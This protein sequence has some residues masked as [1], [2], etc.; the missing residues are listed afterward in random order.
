MV[1]R[2]ILELAVFVCGAVVMIYEII[3]SR[4]VSPFIGTSTYVWTS[5]IGVILAALSL[6]YWLGGR[7]ADRRPHVRI[8]AAVVL[9]AAGLIS[10]TVLLKDLVLTFIG[11]LPTGLEIKAVLASAALFAPASIALGFVTPYAVK[12]KTISLDDT[13]KTVGRLYALSTVG[14]IVGT[15][16]AG[17]VLI[18]FVGSTRTLYILAAVL[19][20]TGVSLAPLKLDRTVVAIIVVF[21]TGIVSNEA[22][23]YYLRT[24]RGLLDIDTEYNRVQIFETTDPTTGRPIRA[25]SI[26]P[27]FVQSTIFLDGP[28][29]YARYT[30][31]YHLVRHLRPDFRR[32]LMIGGAGYSF[33]QDH[34][35]VYPNA[36]IDVVEIDPGMTEIA[37]RH[38]RL[39]DDP[40][41]RIIH[42]DGRVF[43]NRAGSGTYDAVFIDAFSSLFSVPYQ[44]T[45]IEAVKHVDRVLDERGVAIVNIGSALSGDASRFLHAEL[46]TYSAVFPHVDIFKV[47]IDR[48]DEHV[49][50]VILV[51]CKTECMARGSSDDTEIGRML[52]NR[53]TSV[54]P[55]QLPPLTDD[56]APVE[57][58]NSY[59]QNLYRR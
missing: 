36:Q 54:K 55:Y 51:A 58:Y 2:Y 45:T 44:L 31:F 13:G 30:R 35:A 50:N 32:T 16:T 5:L 22:T 11:E 38:F 43:L 57:H 34:L 33:P 1:R 20:A 18:P 42:E 41:L 3:G 19:L 14:S 48:P 4:I 23:G 10:L 25:M 47:Q 53:I 6:G 8:L 59:G 46:A 12:L 15:F 40:R 7:M 39:T 52:E 24:T 27:Y 26:D 9:A 56:L 28:E 29:L 37:R 17:F 49:Q 21:I